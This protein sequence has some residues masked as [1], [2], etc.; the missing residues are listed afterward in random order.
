MKTK[1]CFFLLFLSIFQNSCKKD[2][3]LT[4]KSVAETSVIRSKAPTLERAMN[5]F[6]RLTPENSATGSVHFGNP[7]WFLG[8]EA[9][10]RSGGTV[11]VVPL[12]DS[13]IYQKNKKLVSTSLLF[14]EDSLGATQLQYMIT[15]ADSAYFNQNNGNISAPTFTGAYVL[16]SSMKK[17]IGGFYCDNGNLVGHIDSNAISNNVGVLD[18][19]ICP[20]ELDIYIPCDYV[21][22]A[23]G[24]G[25][26]THTFYVEC[27][28][29]GAG[30]GGG[31][32]GGYGSGWGGS[33]NSGTGGVTTG[34]GGGST[35]GSV[36]GP[37][38]VTIVI[39]QSTATFQ[40][41]FNGTVPITGCGTGC[42][43]STMANPADRVRL[44]SQIKMFKDNGTPL[45]QQ[46]AEWMMANPGVIAMINAALS[47][48]G[49]TPN[50]VAI[51]ENIEYVI[52]LSTLL[53]LDANGFQ[54]L[55]NNPADQQFITDFL[56]QHPNDP[57]AAEAVRHVLN[58]VNSGGVIGLIDWNVIDNW[59][60]DPD[61]SIAIEAALN[62][63]IL[64][65]QNPDKSENWLLAQAWYRASRDEV[66]TALD[67]CGMVEGLGAGCDA[68][69]AV[70]YAIEGD[71]F[72]AGLSAMA[73]V[74]IIGSSR[75]YGR[76]VK[77]A[78][79]LTH[80]V[81]WTFVGGVCHFGNT[82]TLRTQMRRALQ[83]PIGHQA[84]HIIPLYLTDF[85]LVQL[86][87]NSGSNPF[88]INEI[89]NG[90]S[91]PNSLGGNLPR[92]LGSHPA[93]TQRVIKAMNDIMDDIINT[94]P[95]NQQADEAA[96]RLRELVDKINDAVTNGGFAT[97][98]DVWWP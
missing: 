73:V 96:V 48:L 29:G 21:D 82:N 72:N 27:G 77:L 52:S 34:S 39:P 61:G 23:S 59:S 53:G 79:G 89:L 83:T 41:L 46:E 35:G 11:L 3:I 24:C 31:S 75:V 94:V 47:G 18:R 87:A 5:H 65:L 97:I 17:F 64:K 90:I 58:Y 4:Q 80:N 49:E 60:P 78:N 6:S 8:H 44:V 36:N 55:L 20:I 25:T 16:Y 50:L 43:P 38:G 1:I 26:Q 71:N 37:T 84:H 40:D 86:A 92:H 13:I 85:P 57:I 14:V 19:A 66:H 45:L 70:F 56:G 9:L 30:S 98:N 42:W 32:T 68:V 76:M 22:A 69:N 51:I 2:E 7:A 74:P 62:F 67:F 15:S 93:Y 91:L 88:H 81:N 12:V 95:V 28:N 63:Q 33:G 54:L 10:T